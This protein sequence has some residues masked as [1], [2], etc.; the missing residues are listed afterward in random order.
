M[1]K[2]IRITIPGYRFK[3]ELAVEEIVYVVVCQYNDGHFGFADFCDLPYTAKKYS[4]AV[5]MK[6]NIWKC[7]KN[8]GWLKHRIKIAKIFYS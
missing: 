4:E 6:N 8:C 5:K 2:G 1:K 7:S 3:V